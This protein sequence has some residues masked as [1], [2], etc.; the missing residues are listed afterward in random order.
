MRVVVAQ[1]S[2]VGAAALVARWRAAGYDAGLLTVADLS[3]PGWVHD[4]GAPERGRAVIE[5]RALPTRELRAVV[6]RLPAVVP[7]DVAWI[8]EQDRA[9]AAAEMHAF[10]WAW[11]SALPCPVL[12][13]PSAGC[14]AGPAWTA[15]EW[16]ARA[17]RLGIPAPP[18]VRSGRFGAEVP[19]RPPVEGRKAAVHVVGDRAF[20]ANRSEPARAELERLAL[21]VAEDARAELLCVEFRVDPSAGVHM[22]GAGPWVDM[23]DDDVAVAVGARCGVEEPSSATAVALSESAA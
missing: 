23:F 4:P 13:R 22:A 18:S 1:A 11:L 14:L 20:A 3:V 7:A 15:E 5:A 9:Y 2:D 12:N 6:T 8:D 16:L 10:L 19:Q 17:R 21:R